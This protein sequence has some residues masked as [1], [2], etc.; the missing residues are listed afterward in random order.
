VKDTKRATSR[1]HSNT[2]DNI[3]S[4]FLP[5]TSKSHAQKP[6]PVGQTGALSEKDIKEMR[7]HIWKLPAV[8]SSMQEEQHTDFVHVTALVSRVF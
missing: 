7:V 8:L 3:K 1:A 6:V 2:M 4:L 5:A